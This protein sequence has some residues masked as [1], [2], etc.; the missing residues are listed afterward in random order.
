VFF[1]LLVRL[2]PPLVLV[3]VLVLV[4]VPVPVPMLFGA[5]GTG[6]LSKW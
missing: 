2:L 3:L 1:G 6:V 4:P 5:T